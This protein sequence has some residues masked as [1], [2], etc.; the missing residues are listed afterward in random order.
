MTYDPTTPLVASSPLTSASPIQVNF[1]QFA[2]IFSNLSGG[3]IYNHMPLND[4][5]QGKHA[6]ILMQKQVSAPG[7]TDDLVSLFCMDATSAAGTLPQ[8]WM[9]IQKFL[10]TELDGNTSPNNPMQITY[11]S[12]GT[13]GPNFYSFLPGSPTA[14]ILYFGTTTTKNSPITLSPAPTKVIWAQAFPTATSTVTGQANVPYDVYI[15]LGTG[16]IQINSTRAP[17]GASFRYIAIGTV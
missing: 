6:A 3:V 7:V 13:S 8:L 17:G 5:N 16:T 11:N 14:Y 10:P 2:S 9:Q 1:S 4:Q 15:S 12:V